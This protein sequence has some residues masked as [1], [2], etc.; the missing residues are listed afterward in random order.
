M[1]PRDPS[2][3]TAGAS[4]GSRAEQGPGMGQP[5]AGL[6][7]AVARPV[8]ARASQEWVGFV[9]GIFRPLPLRN[10]LMGRLL[11]GSRILFSHSTIRR[12]SE[13]LIHT[14]A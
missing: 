13:Y 14:E 6:R 3:L 12:G 10:Y 5:P 2:R 4:L 11:E 7:W 1:W 9:L 8:P